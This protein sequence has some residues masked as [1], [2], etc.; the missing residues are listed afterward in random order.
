LSDGRFTVN[1][2]LVEQIGIDILP[3]RKSNDDTQLYYH[4]HSLTTA[5]PSEHELHFSTTCL[6]LRVSR[7]CG[8][9]G[10]TLDTGRTEH[11][12][13][14]GHFIVYSDQHDLA[15][16]SSTTPKQFGELCL[17]ST[18]RDTQPEE[19]YLDFIVI[20]ASPGREPFC[21]FE[22]RNGDIAKDTAPA[23]EEPNHLI[24]GQSTSDSQID[25]AITEPG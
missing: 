8:A 21:D 6:K 4:S 2:L 18:W 17:E 24:D 1:K 5:I 14:W 15:D 22:S 16:A 12:S 19:L 20:R 23:S 3:V 13:V 11:A 9:T 7:Y 25:A 10:D